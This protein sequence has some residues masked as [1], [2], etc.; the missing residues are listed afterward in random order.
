VHID[1]VTLSLVGALQAL[2]LAPLL[3]AATL[4][5]TGVARQ[6]L[7]I[8][9]TVLVLQALGWALMGARGQ[10]SDWLSIVLA[11]G[12]LMISYAETARA[13]RLLLD[14]PPRRGLLAA[15]GSGGWLGIVW[16][17]QVQPNYPMRV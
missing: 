9:G 1:L 5:Y 15:I 8:W 16:F 11:N 17:A 10:I 13:L 12:V 6:S 3:L 4:A 7:R 14:A 2:L